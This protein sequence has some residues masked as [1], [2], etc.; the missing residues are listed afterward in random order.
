MSGKPGSDFHHTWTFLTNHA[1]VL[2]CLMADPDLRV[3]DIADQVGI[4]ERAALRIL[5]ELEDADVIVRHREGRRTHYEIHGEC[6]LRHPI[7]EACSVGELL[8]PVLKARALNT[9]RARRGN[10]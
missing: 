5:H 6:P 3:R 8:A 10:G 9:R 4:T 1:H 2:V 7:E